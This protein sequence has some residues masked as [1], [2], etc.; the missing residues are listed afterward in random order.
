MKFTAAA[1]AIAASFRVNPIRGESVDENGRELRGRGKKGQKKLGEYKFTEPADFNGVYHYCRY[2]I[3]RSS[4]TG[5]QTGNF[6]A[7]IGHEN[8]PSW[9]G[10]N[11][12]FI[13]EQEDEFGAYKGVVVDNQDVVVEFPDIESLTMGRFQGFANG[14]TLSLNSIGVG[15]TGPGGVLLNI[16]DSPD[17]NVC[18]LFDNGILECTTILTEYCTQATIEDD[19]TAPFCQ[20]R[21]GEWLNTYSIKSIQVMDG[22][23]C[24]DPPPRFC[25][26]NPLPDFHPLDPDANN[27]DSTPDARRLDDEEEESL[28]PCPILAAHNMH[29]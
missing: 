24:P 10:G 27:T 3:I 14:N 28:H 19:F 21:E 29:G 16:N 7:C 4:S 1:V 2:S 8:T 26:T 5:I 9:V 15:V 17:T 13:L 12:L 20:D 18:T 6:H 23:E 22:F 25:E 11:S